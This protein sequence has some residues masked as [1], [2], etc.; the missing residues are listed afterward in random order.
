MAQFTANPQRFDPYKN[1]KFRVKWDGRVVAGVSKVSAFSAAFVT[2]YAPGPPM[3]S[4]NDSTSPRASGIACAE[5]YVRLGVKRENI[6]L[7]DTK[8]VVYKG[9]TAGM[10]PYK[11]RFAKE[12]DLRTLNEAMSGWRKSR[13]D[14][15]ASNIRGALV[16]C[17]SPR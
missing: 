17:T 5:H 3:P 11:E 6:T 1:F 9:R 7:C 15:H 14:A 13:S 16:P 12:T 8:G 4:A 2:P 10:N